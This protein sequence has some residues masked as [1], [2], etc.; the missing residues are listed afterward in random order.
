MDNQELAQAFKALGDMN[1][2]KM[3]EMIAG[4]D[5][6]CACHLLDAFDFTQ[7]TLSH[8]MK[9]LCSANLIECTKRGRWMHYSLKKETAKR[10]SRYL[11]DLS[12]ERSCGN[13]GQ[14][15]P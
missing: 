10:L 15:R 13:C 8:H 6:I 1:R 11:N 4:Q 14:W 7:P 3:L 9:I 12:S 5:D 2:V